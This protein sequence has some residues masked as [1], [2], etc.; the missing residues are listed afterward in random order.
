M[1]DQWHQMGMMNSMMNYVAQSM[2]PLVGF[3]RVKSLSEMVLISNPDISP[4]EIIKKVNAL[5]SALDAEEEVNKEKEK[6]RIRIS[7]EKIKKQNQEN[8]DSL[9]KA[10]EELRNVLS[11]DA[12]Q[13]DVKKRIDELTKEMDGMTRSES[14][15]EIKKKIK[16]ERKKLS[17]SKI[18]IYE[19]VAKK[20]NMTRHVIGYQ[21]FEKGVCSI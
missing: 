5:I 10:Q 7:D 15:T 9:D 19:R 3:D 12:V 20:Y 6:E 21:L 14:V 4:K 13:V 1:F 8:Q 16:N 18:E 11:R 2:R 17:K